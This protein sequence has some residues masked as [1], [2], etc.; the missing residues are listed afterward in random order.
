MVE[1]E[2]LRRIANRQQCRVGAREQRSR[3]EQVQREV[4]LACRPVVPPRARDRRPLR[5]VSAKAT[6][7]AAANIVVP[8]VAFRVPTL[9]R[10]R[11]RKEHDALPGH[12]QVLFP[13]LGVL[14]RLKARR[15]KFHR[16]RSRRA[17]KR[18][19]REREGISR[20]SE[21]PEARALVATR[22]DVLPARCGRGRGSSRSAARGPR[23]D[24]RGSAAGEHG[25]RL[26]R[27]RGALNCA[28]ERNK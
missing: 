9:C 14:P 6:A 26:P 16:H 19:L 15:D 24:K 3:L 22:V 25:E 12:L 10:R 2:R 7:R 1:V 8:A 18:S 13:R 28:C 11:H 5:L 23:G 20:R 21:A 4:A 27:R 17:V